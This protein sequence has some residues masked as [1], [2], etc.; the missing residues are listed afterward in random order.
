ME[1]TP[2][3]SNKKQKGWIDA[4]IKANKNYCNPIEKKTPNRRRFHN[5]D[6]ISGD[7]VR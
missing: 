3:Q 4:L 7:I 6:W 1:R 5:C 2:T